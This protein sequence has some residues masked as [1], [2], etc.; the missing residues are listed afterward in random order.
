MIMQDR[1]C[2]PN[3][4]LKIMNAERKVYGMD[5]DDQQCLIGIGQSVFGDHR[6]FG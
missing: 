6:S 4:F 2:L 5:I 1:Q 3:L